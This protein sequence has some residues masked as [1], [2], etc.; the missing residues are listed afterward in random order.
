M[1]AVIMAGGSGTRLWPLS[2]RR[3][4]K[5]LLQLVG[6]T[7]LLQQTAARLGRI[8]EPADIYVITSNAHV[9]ATAQ[10]L[11][12]L[13]EGNVLGEPLARST[14]VAAGLAMVL[15]RRADDEVAIVVPADHHVADEDA[16]AEAVREAVRTAERGYL[17]CLGVVPRHPATGYGYIKAGE[18]LHPGGTAAAVERFVEKPDAAT[19]ARFTRK[20]GY[21]WNA[22]VFV[23]R[24][25][26]FRQAVEAYQPALA[27]A[28]DRVAALNRI[29]GWMSDVREIVEPLPA[30]SIDDGI[31]GPSAADGRMAVVPLEAGW[32]DIGSW[33]AMLEALSAGGTSSLV[34]RG[35]HHDRGSEGLLV[36]GGQR[37]VVTVVLRDV[38]IVDTE[39]ALLVCARDRAEQIK[40]V[41]DEIAEQ[42]GDRYL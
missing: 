2:R 33:S 36:H 1:F 34:I 35:E 11:P 18:P 8:L 7:S 6:D 20:R 31:A 21:L 40:P 37:L 26:A 32:S 5:Q 29:P 42:S 27:E 23:W 16:F 17:V 13:P 3:T 41:L 28:L 4:P 25:Y 22:G 15:A 12:H 14:A 38:I 39:D 9:R 30:V 10:Q 19:A 24:L